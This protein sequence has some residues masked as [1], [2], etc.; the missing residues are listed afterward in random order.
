MIVTKFGGAAL[1]D[2]DSF[3]NAIN[4]VASGKDR[5]VLAVL[6]ACYGV[7][8]KL[9]EIASLAPKK[10]VASS[11]ARIRGIKRFHL[12]ILESLIEE[13]PHDLYKSLIID[14]SGGLEQLCEGINLL[15]E[16]TPK[17]QAQATAFGEEYST[18]IF[19][20]ALKYMGLN[21][22]FINS[23]D[24]IKTNG[25]FLNARVNFAKT[26]EAAKRELD[27]AF[28]EKDI[29]ITQG[30]VGS[31]ATGRKT[32]LGRGGSDYS[33][34]ILGAACDAEEI[35]FWK[36][37]PGVL[38]ADPRLVP[39]AKVLTRLTFD[40]M[41]RLSYFGADI[42]HPETIR[43]AVDKDINVIIKSFENP[44]GSGTL[45]KR[46]FERSH[47]VKALTLKKGL[48]LYNVEISD[49]AFDDSVKDLC[50]KIRETGAEI[51]YSI[52][53]SYELSFA[54]D[55]ID[56][57]Q[58]LESALDNY[59]YTASETDL[60]C[61]CG[62]GLVACGGAVRDIVN[63]IFST[64]LKFKPI[65]AVYGASGLSA[66]F[67]VE[68]NRSKEAARAVHDIIISQKTDLFESI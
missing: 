43:P 33:A 7:T 17:T 11:K 47:A 21:A 59:K 20:C 4:I 63:E 45:I 16:I 6:S 66:I 60:L 8:D 64:I 29:V 57:L 5:K 1:K 55:N 25:D 50:D 32:L 39:D 37:V 52:A 14:I 65:R 61:F 26:N 44:E 34:A 15:K 36:D 42:L 46:K 49:I 24:L 27:A 41:K 35:Q 48:R 19:L 13:D 23:P 58:K 53:G 28:S 3:K 10:S 51:L 22:T 54:L 18:A 38:T 68:P 12:Q 31:D 9:I 30:F 56:D 2:A 62:E 40:E 67:F